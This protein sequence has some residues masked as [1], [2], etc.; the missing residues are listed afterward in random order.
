MRKQPA[1]S[2]KYPQQDR[3]GKSDIYKLSARTLTADSVP[4]GILAGSVFTN[5][6]GATAWPYVDA[7]GGCSLGLGDKFIDQLVECGAAR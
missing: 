1:P 7:P 6:Q 3:F 5:Y 4:A 2:A